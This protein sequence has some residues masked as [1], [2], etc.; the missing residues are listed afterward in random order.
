MIVLFSI[1]LIVG[2]SISISIEESF[3]IGDL[4]RD[5]DGVLDEDDQC[6]EIAETYNKFE[7]SDGCPDSV[8]EEKTTFEFPDS[9]GDG[10]EDR[11]DGCVYLPETFNDYLDF[12]GCPEIIP[13]T[14]EDHIDSDSDTIPDTIDACP[15]ERETI[16]EFK[17]SDGCPDSLTSSSDTSKYSSSDNQC[18]DGKILVT[19]INTQFPICVHLDTA[20]KWEKL[21]IGEIIGPVIIEG[22]VNPEEKQD[23][24]LPEIKPELPIKN[25]FEV[26][27]VSGKISM[28]IGID[29]SVEGNVGGN[30]GVSAGSD[31]LLIIDDGM[32]FALDDIKEK[33]SE[34]RTC[35]TCDNV[36][37]LLNTH[38]HIDHVSN[39]AYFGEH[40]TTIVAHSNVRD[41]L[42]SPQEQKAFGIK[43]DAYPE[44]ALPIITFDDSIFL[45]FNEEKIQ[46]NYLPNGHT[47]SDSV[48]YFTN[49]N[50]LHL[51][52]HF[53]NGMFPFVDLEHGGSVQGLTRNVEKIIN[54]YPED[55]NIIPGHGPLS[56]MEDLVEYHTMLVETTKIIQ[57]QMDAGTS[58]EEIQTLGFPERWQEWEGAWIDEATWIMIVHTSL[59]LN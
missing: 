51:G 41:L 21:G 22:P 5:K 9:D 25:K 33:L 15:N 37:F 10:I 54:E 48:V 39:N 47:D 3:S 27:P 6:P 45:Y 20:K 34:L 40:D 30:I 57:D 49:S 31:G 13:E 14:S 4:D 43:F 36:E 7:D 26:I 18:L 46:V 42:S 50:V 29:Q 35:F 56:E 2:L 8:T 44:E 28:L 53:F 19:R 59:S 1:F 38:W 11:I 52:D 58:L 24:I 12:D 16:N 55:V 17:D 32:A 23:D